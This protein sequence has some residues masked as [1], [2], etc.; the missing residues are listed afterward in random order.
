MAYRRNAGAV[1][2]KVAY[3]YEVTTDDDFF[4]KLVEQS[5]RV[6][7]DTFSSPYMI[8]FF[9]IRRYFFSFSLTTP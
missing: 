5:F 7:E 1:I 9:P 8:D 3:G 6:I 4:V 2:M